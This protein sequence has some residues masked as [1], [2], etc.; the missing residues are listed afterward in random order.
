M[1]VH[2]A[3]NL[4][5]DDL[6]VL[7]CHFDESELVRLLVVAVVAIERSVPIVAGNKSGSVVL[8]QAAVGV[9]RNSEYFHHLFKLGGV[10]RALVADLHAVHGAT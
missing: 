8:G 4:F 7:G 3:E 10:E 9:M 6:R 1:F 5:S 2:W